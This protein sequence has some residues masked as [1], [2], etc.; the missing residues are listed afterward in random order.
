M[1]VSCLLND[2]GEESDQRAHQQGYVQRQ[3]GRGREE[4]LRENVPVFKGA[5]AALHTRGPCNII[6]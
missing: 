3:A 1:G 2:E 6:L 5:I 4:I